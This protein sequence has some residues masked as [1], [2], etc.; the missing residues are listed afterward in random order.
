VI[1]GRAYTLFH[2][3][4][5]AAALAADVVS[6]CN[7][8]MTFCRCC[9]CCC[10]LALMQV[11]A[12]LLAHNL[13][14]SPTVHHVGAAPCVDLLIVCF[15][16]CCRSLMQV[17]AVLP[18]RNRQLSRAVNHVAAA[19]CVSLLIL[20]CCCCFV[21]AMCRWLPSYLPA[22]TSLPPQSIMWAL[23]PASPC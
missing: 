21:V 1:N 16:C 9:C 5:S 10:C 23:L 2:L 3:C 19:A 7:C 14:L 11:A 12:V 15:C 20:S 13:Q 6:R 22:T 17:A 18:A 4:L 8:T